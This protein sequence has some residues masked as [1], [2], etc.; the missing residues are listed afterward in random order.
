MF[1]KQPNSLNLNL[2]L[3]LFSPY[4]ENEQKGSTLLS[5]CSYVDMSTRKNEYGFTFT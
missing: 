3:R 4:C 1:F 5:L 2:F